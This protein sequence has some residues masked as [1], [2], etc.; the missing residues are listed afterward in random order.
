VLNPLRSRL[1][2]WPEILAVPVDLIGCTI[3]GLVT[4]ALLE[5]PLQRLGRALSLPAIT[6]RLGRT[7]A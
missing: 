5:R 2:G 4:Y 1:A 7:A 3:L 6:A